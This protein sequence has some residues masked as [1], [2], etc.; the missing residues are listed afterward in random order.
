MLRLFGKL[1]WPSAHESHTC[2][3]CRVLCELPL[4]WRSIQSG[5][6][7]APS[8]WSLQVPLRRCTP[9]SGLSAVLLPTRLLG[10]YGV[11]ASGFPFACLKFLHLF[12]VHG[13]VVDE[14]A[15][16]P[17]LCWIRPCV[18]VAH[19]MKP[20]RVELCRHC[21]RRIVPGSWLPSRSS[22]K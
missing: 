16:S 9:G 6:H 2:T 15:S 22:S 1:Y 12:L 4:P 19:T 8:P 7:W 3:A 13:Y 10:L 11:S 20:I 14:F 21:L 17:A 5:V 18:D